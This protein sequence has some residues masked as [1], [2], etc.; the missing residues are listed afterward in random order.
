M[1][2][3]KLSLTLPEGAAELV[4]R[5]GD[6]V[7]ARYNGQEGQE[8]FFSILSESDGRFQF[9]PKLPEEDKGRPVLGTFMEMLLEGLRRMDE[10]GSCGESPGETLI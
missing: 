6:L 7:H 4:F 3:G 1:K 9:H 10:A 2:T 5:E 8:A